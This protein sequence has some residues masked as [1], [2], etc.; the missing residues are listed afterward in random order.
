MPTVSFYPRFLE[1]DGY[2]DHDAT[3]FQV[4]Y[5]G[6][7]GIFAGREFLFRISDIDLPSGATITSANIVHNV[8]AKTPTNTD[9]WFNYDYWI[10]CTSPT[11]GIVRQDAAPLRLSTDEDLVAN[12][13][14]FNIVANTTWNWPSPSAIN[15]RPWTIPITSYVQQAVNTNGGRHMNFAFKWKC[16][17]ENGDLGVSTYANSPNSFGF[18]TNVRLDITYTGGTARNEVVL[19][20]ENS[21]FT[22]PI[23]TDGTPQF[24]YRNGVYGFFS[25]TTAYSQASSHAGIPVAPYGGNIIKVTGTDNYRQAMW[26]RG[27][28][29]TFAPGTWSCFSV[30]VYVPSGQ[31]DVG[32]IKLNNMYRLGGNA[33]TS[34]K[35]QW[36]RLYTTTLHGP[37]IAENA[38]LAS[39]DSMSSGSYY[40][41]NAN[42]TYG[43]R[44]YPYFDGNTADSAT[45]H[46]TFEWGGGTTGKR[47][48]GFGYVIL[49]NLPTVTPQ[50]P[51][52]PA[53]TQRQF[54]TRWTYTDP[55]GEAQQ[56]FR[57][58][59]RKK[60]VP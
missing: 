21:N 37:D 10:E 57:V 12:R 25:N 36:V 47:D 5:F 9:N 60:R 20:V 42:W 1:Q 46:R 16:N 6:G 52:T 7:L 39:S 49:D 27:P 50:N 40:V 15:D 31:P 59:V 8:Y 33:K 22:L 13:N 24:W 29:D 28:S 54:T 38:G 32:I 41:A 35:D 58:E 55:Y 53:S 4:N 30:F 17:S 2:T 45:Y 51:Q 23:Q 43:R 11:N 3:K 19:G 26:H 56:R 48:G 14:W 18:A 44:L 34:T